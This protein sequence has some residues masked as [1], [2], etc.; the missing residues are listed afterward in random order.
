MSANAKYHGVQ[1]FTQGLGGMISKIEKSRLV[2]C[3]EEIADAENLGATFWNSLHSWIY[4]Q[5][6]LPPTVLSVMSSTAAR[7]GEAGMV[8]LKLWHFI[9]LQKHTD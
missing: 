5:S 4:P 7:G 2:P 3:S 8:F 1:Q 6:S 9:A